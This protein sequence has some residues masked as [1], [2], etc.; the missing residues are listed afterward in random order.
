MT[1]K[2]GNY[3]IGHQNKRFLLTSIQ[4]EKDEAPELENINIQEG[5][6]GV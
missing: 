6:E 2:W 4:A 3:Y 1:R 5:G